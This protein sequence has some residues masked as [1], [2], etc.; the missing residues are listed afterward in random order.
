MVMLSEL[1]RFRVTDDRGETTALADL[2]ISQL[3]TDYPLI[4]HL[5]Y[6]TNCH[7]TESVLTWDAVKS[8]GP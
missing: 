8:N 1:L 6:R 5:I 7:C 4:T 3:D 2:A